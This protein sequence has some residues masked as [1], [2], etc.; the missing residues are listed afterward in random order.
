MT[1][2]AVAHIERLRRDQQTTD[3]TNNQIEEVAA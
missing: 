2:Q 1:P 3:T